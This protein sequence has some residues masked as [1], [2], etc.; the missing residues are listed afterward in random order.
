VVDPRERRCGG[1][2][3]YGRRGS[4]WIKGRHLEGAGAIEA[5]RELPNAGAGGGGAI[6][7]EYG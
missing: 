7:V 3:V 6:A 1:D 4:I 5:R 2:Y